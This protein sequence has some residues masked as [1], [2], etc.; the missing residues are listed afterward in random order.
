MGS[1]DWIR[2]DQLNVVYTVFLL[3]DS[4]VDEHSKSAI[5]RKEVELKMDEGNAVGS[6]RQESQQHSE[7][8]SNTGFQRIRRRRKALQGDRERGASSARRNKAM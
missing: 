4:L 1:K 8:G 3:K 2:Q 5:L 7:D 6:G